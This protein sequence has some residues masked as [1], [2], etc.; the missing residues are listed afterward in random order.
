M[1]RDSDFSRLMGYAG[2]YRILTYLSWILSTLS[3]LLAL[4]PFVFIFFIIR[5]VLESGS[6][7]PSLGWHAV[8]SALL[9]LLIYTC[10]LMCSHLSA[11]RVASNM[12]KDLLRHIA[13]LP[14]GEAKDFPSGKLRKIVDEATTVNETYLAHQLPDT[15]S[16]YATPLGLILMLFAFDWRLGLLSLIPVIISLMIMM[17]MIGENMQKEMREYNNA[18]DLM[19]AEAVEYVRGVPL[20]KT[21]GQSI[22]S[23]R[24]FKTAI[25]NY[26]EWVIRYTMSMKRPMIL[27]TG[28]INAIFALLIAAAF[29]FSRNGLTDTEILNVIFYIIITPALSVTMTK[30]MFKSSEKMKVRDAMERID[31]VLALK[32]MASPVNGVLPDDGC[33]EIKDLVFSY[34]GTRNSVDGISLSIPEGS[35]AAFVGPSGGGKTTLSQ[36]IARFFDPDSGSIRIGGVDVKD[37]RK[38]DLMKTVSFVFQDSHLV[39]GTI[40]ENVMMGKKDATREEAMA[41]LRAAQCSDILEKLPKGADT[42]LGSEGIYLSGGETQRI[43]IARVMLRNTPI[44]ILDE[45]TAFADPDNEEK[46]QKAFTELSRNR[47]VI[48]IAHRL[49]SII[50]ADRIYVIEGGKVKEEGNARSLMER[51]GMFRKIWD[52]YQASI[53]WKVKEA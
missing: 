33:I 36:L 12:K 27:Y 45:A 51:N 16:A 3:A 25:D 11:F 23:F 28:C 53:S 41:A 14:L 37:I 5:E 4:L 50:N 48:M 38:E 35:L 1:N 18:L 22:Y 24:R 46:M 7:E 43:A 31:S 49:S 20:I 6:A 29:V 44:V 52:E 30:I 34:D 40:L 21:F 42:L 10:A 47:T 8:A 39:K 13:R 2:K 15:A 17:S 32:P 26:G 9:S 19:A